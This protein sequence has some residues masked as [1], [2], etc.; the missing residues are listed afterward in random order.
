MI[1]PTSA[2]IVVPRFGALRR[3]RNNGRADSSAAVQ[4]QGRKPS[5]QKAA[6]YIASPDRP[7]PVTARLAKQ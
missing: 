2:V 3:I 1:T 4:V 6:Q 7:A 5:D